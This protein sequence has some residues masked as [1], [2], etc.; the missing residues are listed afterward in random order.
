MF[1]FTNIQIVMEY[2]SELLAG[3]LFPGQPMAVLTSTVYGRQILSQ[4]LNMISD[5]KFCFYMKIPERELFFAQVYGTMLGPFV[6]YA[7]M[8]LIID[9]QRPKLTGEVA[10]TAWNALKTKN[11]YSLSVIWGVLG[12]RKFF[13]PDSGYGWISDRPTC[14]GDDM[15][16]PQVGTALGNREV[17]QPSSDLQRRNPFSHLYQHEPHDLHDCRSRLR[18]IRLSLPPS[19]VPQI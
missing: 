5:M 11:F 9:T 4:C 14:S 17:H 13:G 12:P 19:L 8:R 3:A 15:A 1:V 6:N 16:Y 2:L 18:G 10:S 7:C